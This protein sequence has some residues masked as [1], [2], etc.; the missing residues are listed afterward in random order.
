[1]VTGEQDF[2]EDLQNIADLKVEIN[3]ISRD[4]ESFVITRSTLGSS[5]YHRAWRIALNY[6]L[7][8]KRRQLRQKRANL[9][10]SLD[11]LDNI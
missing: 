3:K 6:I 9:A 10:A 2:T 7:V 11:R 5:D 4:I 1:M 8:I